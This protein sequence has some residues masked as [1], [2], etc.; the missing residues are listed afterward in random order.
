MPVIKKM[1]YVILIFS[2]ELFNGH[3]KHAIKILCSC[4][5]VI[6]LVGLSK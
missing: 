5:N 2:L 1:V 3:K 6:Q 4:S